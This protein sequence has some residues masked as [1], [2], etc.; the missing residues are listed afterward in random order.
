MR[1]LKSIGFLFIFVL[2]NA[3][4]AQEHG[5]PKKEEKPAEGA[6]TTLN[7]DYSGKQNQDWEKAQ[8]KLGAAKGKMDAQMALLQSLI[9]DKERLKGK[10]RADKVEELKSEHIKLRKYIEEYNELNDEFLTK[11]PEKGIKQSRIYKRVKPKTLKAYEEDMTVHGRVNKL[12][13]KIMKQYPKTQD[14]DKNGEHV[15]N[16]SHRNNA[17]EGINTHG[18]DEK[19]VTGK[20]ILKK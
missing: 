17:K 18:T 1:L 19:E 4:N 9:A 20:I 3:V 6:A 5:A 16:K 15:K 14:N 2:L 8:A 10:E 7:Q 12:H 11:F 13:S